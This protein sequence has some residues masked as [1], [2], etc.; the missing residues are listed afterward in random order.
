MFKPADVTLYVPAFKAEATLPAC[1]EAVARQTAA[2]G[3]IIIV[4]DGSLVPVSSSLGEV[5]RHNQNLGLAA[6]RNTALEA[7][8]SPLLAALDADVVPEPDWLERL[9]E[10]LASG[11]FA[12]AG[13]R[14]IEQEQHNTADQ[15]R[16]THMA[17]HW[18]GEPVR[19]PRFLF[20][21]NTIFR[22]HA[23]RDAGG[24]NPELRTNNEDFT[25]CEKLYAAGHNLF[26]TPAACARH[27]RRDTGVQ[28]CAATE[29]HHAKG[30]RATLILRPPS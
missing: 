23:L 22:T 28:S 20:G 24:Y 18:G 29:G 25:L 5:I 1:M 17:Q 4:D 9:L 2:P 21:A 16:A 26:Y 30:S 6:S 7:C 12:G 14:L 10:A 8:R 15:W 13:G 11:N 27:L 19:N 3:R